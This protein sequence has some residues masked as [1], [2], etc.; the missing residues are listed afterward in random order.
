MSASPAPIVAV[1]QFAQARTI[2]RYALRE[3]LRRRV[4][5]IVAALTFA[6]LVLYALGA[7]FA[8]Q[9][10]GDNGHLGFQGDIDDV[11]LAG[12]TLTGMAMFAT[13]FLGAVIA[14]FLTLGVIRGDAEAGLLQPIAARPLSRATIL[15]ARF[16]G[17]AAVAVAYVVVV[18]VIAIL[19]TSVTGGWTP[20]RPIAACANLAGAVAVITCISA[21]VS[22]FT[23]S[24]AQG[25]TVLMLFGAGLTAGLLGQIGDTLGSDRLVQISDFASRLLPFEALYQN[26]LYSLTAEISGSTGFLLSL[27]PFGGA[28][29]SGPG[30]IAFAVLYCAAILTGAAVLF[31]RRDL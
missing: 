20:D 19:I 17:A 26:G 21:L 28:A 22:A 27:G 31:G 25:I 14:T 13:L 6:F 30:L 10:V 2:V 15:L 29:S 12:A 7:H 24:T 16:A 23:G 8:F 9:E 1:G 11:S 4:V 18:F 3:S 5:P